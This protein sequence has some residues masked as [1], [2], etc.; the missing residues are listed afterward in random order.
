MDGR[1]FRGDGSHASFW[2][3]MQSGDWEPDLLA[4]L[5]RFLDTDSVYY[6]VG[7]WIGPTTLYAAGRC[8]S[9]YAFEP[10]P[11]AYASLL[12]NL[13]HNE[14]A[15]VRAFNVAVASTDGTGVIRPATGL[16][17]SS[18]RIELPGK[19]HGFQFPVTLVT[20]ETIM[21]RLSCDAPTF[22]KMDIEGGEFDLVPAIGGHLARLRSLLHLSFH[23]RALPA[24]DR[25]RKLNA[26]VDAL[27]SYEVALFNDEPM[28]IGQLRK[29][30][31][32]WNYSGPDDFGP[33]LLLPPGVRP[34]R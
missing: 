3:A 14:F 12:R 10:D 7:A 33:V 22:I 30:L 9:V 15:N 29:T 25:A 19:G 31:T 16:G 23:A 20:L 28:T 13:T 4:T 5:R 24:A 34:F 1:E 2:A 32:G 11:I 8:R 6:D 18:S 27:E 26:L 21:T 17:D